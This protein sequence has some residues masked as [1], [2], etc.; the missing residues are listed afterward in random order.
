MRHH[1]FAD[2]S[3]SMRAMILLTG[4]FLT[5]VA[6]KAADWKSFGNDRYGFS[7]DV[8]ASFK[9]SAPPDNIRCGAMRR[10]L[11]ILPVSDADL[12]ERPTQ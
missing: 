6:V 5:P 3:P 2:P 12:G 8:P 7:V 10:A 1:S 11:S 4:L 9:A